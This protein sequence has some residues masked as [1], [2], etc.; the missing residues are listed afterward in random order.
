M[1]RTLTAIALALVLVAGFWGGRLLAAQN[2]MIAARDHLRNARRELQ[3]AVA[4]KGGHRERAIDIVN[5][6]I[7]EVDAGIEYAR[8]H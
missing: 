5:N 8:T 1:K 6:A 3:A 2:H 7:G 4:D